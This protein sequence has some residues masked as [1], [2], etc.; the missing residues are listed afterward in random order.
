MKEDEEEEKERKE[1][2][3]EEEKQKE[4]GKTVKRDVPIKETRQWIELEKETSGLAHL[5]RQHP[6]PASPHR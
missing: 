1:E 5:R 4:G 6:P 3:E 2:E